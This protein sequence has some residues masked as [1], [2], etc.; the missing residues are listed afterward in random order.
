MKTYI[1]DEFGNLILSRLITLVVGMS[2]TIYLSSLRWY[3][4]NIQSSIKSYV[5]SITKDCPIVH[6]SGASLDSVTYD[7]ISTI[8]QYIS[9]HFIEMDDSEFAQIKNSMIENIKSTIEVI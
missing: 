8:T 2:L 4:P 3:K 1:T 6:S 5:E 7:G 9:I